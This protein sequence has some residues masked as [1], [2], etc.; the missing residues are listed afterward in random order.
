MTLE[1]QRKISLAINTD[2]NHP[3]QAPYHPVSHTPPSPV[4]PYMRKHSNKTKHMLSSN[5]VTPTQANG[6][7]LG[8][9]D[10]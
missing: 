3:V 5:I 6:L 8:T 9:S 1:Q 2:Q 7:S 10:Q 4:L